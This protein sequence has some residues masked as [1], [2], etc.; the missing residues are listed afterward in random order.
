MLL[1]KI[2]TK[3]INNSAINAED[4]LYV[5]NLASNQ[6]EKLFF[7][8]NKLRQLYF[9]NKIHLCGILNAKSGKCS[10]DCCYCAQSIHHKTDI[11]SYNMLPTGQILKNAKL[12][13]KNGVNCFSLVTS[14]KGIVSDHDFN[15]ILEAIRKSE[16]QVVAASLGI[17]NYEQLLALK[18]A[19]LKKYH[20]NL[21]TSESFFSK[22]CTTHTFAQ[23]RETIKNAR[24]AGL[25]IC[26]GG[27]MGLG[28][29]LKQRIELAFTL[30]ELAA[31]SI[32]LNFLHAIPGTKIFDSHIPLTIEEILK[33]IAMFRL[34]IGRAHV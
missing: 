33:T 3:I 26:S 14:G 21:E 22:V 15:T 6:L 18:K 9:S 8:T 31:D 11:S 32:P 16:G 19:G 1:K 4:A 5:L 25:E 12:A 28:E 24:N 20:H 17:L 29:S 34:E 13:K 7:Y 2:Y 27:I 10:E 23:R 30:R